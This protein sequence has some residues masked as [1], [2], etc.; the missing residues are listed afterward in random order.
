M[1]MFMFMFMLEVRG[2]S[3]HLCVLPPD[4]PVFI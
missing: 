3:L 2:T 1:F 4:F